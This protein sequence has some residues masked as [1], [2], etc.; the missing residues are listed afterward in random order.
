MPWE[1]EASPYE[2]RLDIKRKQNG[3]KRGA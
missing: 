1:E 2:L 3:K